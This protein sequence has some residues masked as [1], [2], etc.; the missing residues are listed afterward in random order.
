MTVNFFS[1]Y[2][3]ATLL[4]ISMNTSY[5]SGAAQKPTTLTASRKFSCFLRY[6]KSAIIDPSG[7]IIATVAWEKTPAGNKIQIWSIAASNKLFELPGHTN[8]ITAM[9]FSRDGKQL[10]SADCTG[11]VHI[12]DIESKQLIQTLQGPRKIIYSVL[13][14]PDGQSIATTDN[15]TLTSLWNIANGTINCQ[16]CSPFSSSKIIV[17]NTDYFTD[18][19]DSFL[20]TIT[21][22]FSRYF[23]QDD[24]YYY[25]CI[26]PDKTKTL[27]TVY[28]YIHIASIGEKHS[29]SIYTKATHTDPIMSTPFNTAH[30]SP[31]G[32][33]IVAA[34]DYQTIHVWDTATQALLYTFK[35]DSQKKDAMFYS[36]FF[37]PTGTEII[38]AA[39]DNTIRILTDSRWK[40]IAAVLARGLHERLGT[41]SP[42]NIMPQ[43]LI[44]EIAKLAIENPL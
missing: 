29:E 14:S 40:V 26:S 34:Y 12:W 21:D 7:S 6:I 37:S 22:Q 23:T 11:I 5:V 3:L 16:Q 10:A 4:C 33:K 30:F 24:P 8:I 44:G 25:F 43:I 31:D 35:L 9:A 28:H 13:F 15:D 17:E 42:V 18:K 2:L 41:E 38:T 27:L 19:T 32:T 20:P 39:S 1:K 36:A